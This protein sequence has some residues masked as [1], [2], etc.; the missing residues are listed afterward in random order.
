MEPKINNKMDVTR[1][2]VQQAISETEIVR[3]QIKY[4]EMP[5]TVPASGGKTVYFLY[6][7][8]GWRIV[9][10]DI[11]EY[12]YTLEYFP[13]V[14]TS[15]PDCIKFLILRSRDSVLYKVGYRWALYI[16]LAD[17][18]GLWSFELVNLTIE[19]SAL[20]EKYNKLLLDHDKLLKDH[21]KILKNPNTDDFA[22][23]VH[24]HQMTRKYLPNESCL[25]V[26]HN[27]PI[28]RSISEYCKRCRT[29]T[30]I[31]HLSLRNLECD[32]EYGYTITEV[33]EIM[34]RMMKIELEPVHIYI[35]RHEHPSKIHYNIMIT[36]RQGKFNDYI[37]DS[38]VRMK[39]ITGMELE[40][41]EYLKEGQIQ[42][43]ERNPKIRVI[44]SCVNIFD[45]KGFSK[46]M[47]KIIFLFSPR[48]IKN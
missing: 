25:E 41:G 42:K 39:K 9:M 38:P 48:N 31:I 16:T 34:S 14:N 17:D 11:M 29:D 21:D 15:D 2:P 35:T 44:R 33:G 7:S 23:Y 20:S 43:L 10:Y 5:E 47:Y 27:G 30:E 46:N 3:M 28:T 45:D 8:T 12:S 6:S 32:Y 26:K 22:L 37:N 13:L 18:L 4:T 24:V 19:L 40:H 36:Y 1:I